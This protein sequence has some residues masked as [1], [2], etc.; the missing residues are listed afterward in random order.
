MSLSQLRR[1]PER[2][3]NR[4]AT[5]I[6]E[7]IRATNSYSSLLQISDRV[8][9][10]S[11]PTDKH[12]SIECE[13]R[14]SLAAIVCHFASSVKLSASLHEA[15]DG[16]RVSKRHR[17]QAPTVGRRKRFKR[18]Q[19]DAENVS[20]ADSWT[21]KTRDGRFGH[22]FRLS[23]FLSDFLSD[24]VPGFTLFIASAFADSS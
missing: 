7:A 24:S 13:T 16:T 1:H 3:A 20:S 11:S 10:N 4:D 14:C 6:S 19:L 23:F 18:R 2:P 21:Q 17:L 8:K 22:Y 15:N 5:A 12:I 9:R